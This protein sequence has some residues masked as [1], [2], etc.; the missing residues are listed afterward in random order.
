MGGRRGNRHLLSPPPARYI[1]LPDSS[2]ARGRQ[3]QDL[4]G[5]SHTHTPSVR[6]PI[7]LVLEKASINA[8][9]LPSPHLPSLRRQR[10]RVFLPLCLI[11]IRLFS[12]IKS[13]DKYCVVFVACTAAVVWYLSVSGKLR[14]SAATFFDFCTDF[15]SFFCWISLFDVHRTKK[16]GK[17]RYFHQ[18]I[19]I[20][21]RIFFYFRSL[22]GSKN[23]I[24]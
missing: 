20:F 6:F 17:R 24:F 5:I 10:K 13:E 3:R 1:F 18:Q 22:Y 12:Q 14:L 8:F 21:I 2:D 7:Q 19:F 15:C 11:D 9:L 4:N 23:P 16:S